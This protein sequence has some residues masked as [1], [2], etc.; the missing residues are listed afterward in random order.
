MAFINAYEAKNDMLVVVDVG[1]G[2]VLWNFMHA[3][4]R[5]M[6]KHRQGDLLY[7]RYILEDKEKGSPLAALDI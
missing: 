5:A 6:N 1:N 4:S 3:P 2:H 7:K